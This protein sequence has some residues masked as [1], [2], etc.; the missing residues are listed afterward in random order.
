MPLTREDLEMTLEIIC[1]QMMPCPFC[2]GP[3]TA[4]YDGRTTV[5]HGETEDRTFIGCETCN[6]GRIAAG[7]F[8]EELGQSV[9]AAVDNWNRRL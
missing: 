4:R 8:D 5:A 2:G 7:R 3:P 1:S 6:I 9:K